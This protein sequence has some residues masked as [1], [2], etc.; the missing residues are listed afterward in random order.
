[1]NISKL[2]KFLLIPVVFSIFAT[3][4][5]SSA[6]AS[7]SGWLELISNGTAGSPP[8]RASNTMSA[9]DRN[10]NRFLV[11]GGNDGAHSDYFNDLW[12]YTKSN[13]WTQLI[14]NGAANSPTKRTN[15][16]V[17]WDSNNQRLFL[18]G[19]FNNYGTFLNDFW[20]YTDANGWT[21]LNGNNAPNVPNKRDDMI[22]VWDDS[23]QRILLFAG[24][25]GNTSGGEYNYNDLWQY[26]DTNGWSQLI[27]NEN[28]T[29]P[30]IRA[31]SSFTWNPTE[32]ALYVFGGIKSVP[33][34]G[35]FILAND[36]WKYTTSNGWQLLTNDGDTNSPSPRMR[37]TGVWDQQNNRFLMFA[38]QTGGSY[39]NDL[40][41]YTTSNGWKV[42]SQSGLTDS[43][44]HR[45]DHA[46]IWDTQNN[47]ML[48]FAGNNGS[49]EVNELWEYKTTHFT[50][51]GFFNPVNNQPILNVSKAGSTI[52]LKWS[53]NNNPDLSTFVSLTSKS[54][55]CQTLSGIEDPI[56]TSTTGNTQ[57]T[58]DATTDQFQYNI[59]TS[60]SWANTCRQFTL[61]LS[62]T[63][64]HAFDVKFK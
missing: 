49:D 50:F 21:Q 33:G 22:M 23:A 54:V 7:T 58:Y 36:L 14:P 44:I 2:L 6:T 25:G 43:P 24:Q 11:F 55:S 28:P 63:S 39:D 18:F 64:T 4:P 8:A 42:I 61:T 3:L 62:D 60:K 15:G 1:M 16:A 35:P 9:W 12:Q 57:L 37:S 56:P 45:A 27:A 26:T 59:S 10:N 30:H 51:T 41:E 46:A 47:R 38:G 40:W 31:G 53:L 17:V 19:G 20:Q 29:S 13:G 34:I 32:N 5:T 48:V 52:P